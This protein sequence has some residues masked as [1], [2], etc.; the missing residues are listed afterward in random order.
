MDAD[1]E[2]KMNLSRREIRVLLFHEFRLG[3]KATEASNNICSTVGEDVLSIRTAQHCFNRF[4]NGNLEL[5]DSPRSGRP[6]VKE[7][8]QHLRL[9]HT[10]RRWCWVFGGVSMELFTGKFFQMFAPSL[11][12]CTVNNWTGL[13]INSRESMIEF[14]N[15]IIT[16]DPM[17]QS[18][19]VKNYW[20]SN[21]LPFLI[22]LILQTWLQRTTICFVL[23]LIIYVRKSST[24]RTTWKW[25][26]PTSL[27]KSPSTSTN[28]ASYLCQSVD[29]KS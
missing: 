16:Q 29:D 27:V 5:D 22:H 13:P 12:I 14:T 1:H 20:S 26:S 3:P 6:P 21:G 4:K 24:T 18:R 17:L 23:F 2:L 8:Y 7:A 9:I 11:L 25:I 15:C 10:P 28:A 19:P